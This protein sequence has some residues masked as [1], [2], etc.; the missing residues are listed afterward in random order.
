MADA[1]LHSRTT[2]RVIAILSACANATAT[3]AQEDAPPPHAAIGAAYAAKIAASAVLVG[4]RSLASVRATEFAPDT[5]LE[6]LLLA[7]LEL[8][9]DPDAGVV[10]ATVLGV[11]RRAV[12]RAGLGCALVLPDD[13][14]TARALAAQR[15][16]APAPTA[17]S[18]AGARAPWPLGNATDSRPWPKDVDRRQLEAALDAA[19]AEPDPA[20]PVRTFAVV[21]ARHG[22]LL[23]ERYGAGID[24]ATPLAGWSM[25]KSVAG[26]LVGVRAAEIGADLDAPAGLAAW[27]SD[28]DARGAIT[29][30]QLLQMSA[31]L[32]FDERYDDLT[33]D[34]PRMLFAAPSAAA[35]AA[36]RPL[37][38][39]PGT[40]FAYSSGT[41]NA[42]CQWLRESFDDHA[43][44]L[45]YPQS[46]LFAP[47]GMLSAVLETDASG[48]FVGSSF[49]HATARDWARLGQLYLDDGVRDGQRLLPPGWVDA[50]TTPAPAAPRRNYGLHW[51]LNRGPED[52]PD[53]RPFPGLPRD[54]YYASGY[55]GQV[56]AVFPSE[57]LVVVRLGCT[58]LR[59][60]WSMHEFLAAVYA[61]CRGGTR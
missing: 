58:K 12:W 6:A 28:D 53:Q 31:G 46:A 41:T 9:A 40:H 23:V 16:P 56:L 19:F 37:V 35:F 27:S 39:P 32:Q 60:A 42:L 5:P 36:A 11:R 61:A 18:T 55:Q 8:E 1:V 59:G 14:D 54:V 34:P 2:S 48:T 51:W 52:A 3:P 26:T 7:G 17:A 49:C 45:A 38:A 13:D 15:A 30:R 20:L 25:A 44:A 4:G 10:S 22:R 47:A 33:A 24:A 50:A 43:D 21:V 57:R 29:L